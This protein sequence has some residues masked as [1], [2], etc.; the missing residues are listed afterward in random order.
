[1]AQVGGAGQVI[2]LA[3]VT[4]IDINRAVEVNK[5]YSVYSLIKLELLSDNVVFESP[6][7]LL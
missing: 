6:L 5:L 1:M 7:L 2:Y 3:Q 4:Y